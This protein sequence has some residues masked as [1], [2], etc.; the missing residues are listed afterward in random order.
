MSQTTN[1][2]LTSPRALASALSPVM[3]FALDPV[4]PSPRYI[5]LDKLREKMEA[6]AEARKS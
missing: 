1:M 6:E 2:A 3:A 5:N 4:R